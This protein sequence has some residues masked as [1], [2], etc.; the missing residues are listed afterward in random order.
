[1]ALAV[2]SVCAQATNGI[3][4]DF[5]TSMGSF[6]C[7]LDYAIAPKAVA[8]FIGLVTGQQPWVD[9]NTGRVRTNSYHNGLTFHRVIAGFMIQGGSRNGQGTDGPGYVFED[10]FSL[11]AR[12]DSFGVLACANSGPDSNGA[13]YFVTVAPTPWLNDVHTIFGRLVGGS[14]VVYAISRVVTG[15]GDKPLTNVVVNTVGIRRV[16]TAAQAFDI[17]AQGLPVATNAPLVAG[18]LPGNVS[19]AFTNRLYADNKLFA[20]SD[21]LGWTMDSLGID[22][23]NPVAQSTVVTN[24]RSRRFFRLAQIQYPASTLAPKTV[25]NRNL[26]LNFSPNTNLS[27]IPG[28]MTIAFNAIGLG[29]ATYTNGASGVAGTVIYSSWSQ[30]PYRGRLYAEFDFFYPIQLRLDYTNATQGNFSGSWFYQYVY[31]YPVAGSFSMP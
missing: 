17:K 7:R 11:S 26:T 3:Y 20:S 21:Y 5:S 10:E 1:M 6:T 19:L 31:T 16:G 25:Y 30:E 14:N 4:A 12:F 22:L 9:L 23:S 18:R 8:N 27:T 24:D 28:R 15:T 2:T 29:P 13:Q